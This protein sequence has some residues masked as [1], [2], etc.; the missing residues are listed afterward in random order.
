MRGQR[1]QEQEQERAE[2]VG[3]KEGKK[4]QQKRGAGRSRGR[5]ER[6]SWYV[7]K[8]GKRRQHRSVGSGRG[9]TGGRSRQVGKFASRAKETAKARA[10]QMAV[11]ISLNL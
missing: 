9:G 1:Q 6:A 5:R 3:R 7:R 8:E 11:G 10:L 4:R 2:W